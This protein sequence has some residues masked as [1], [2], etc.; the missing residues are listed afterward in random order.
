MQRDRI[1]RFMEAIGRDS[2][3]IVSS[4]SEVTRSNDT[5]YRFRPNSDFYYLTGFH[6]PDSIAVINPSHKDHKYVLF[7][8]PRDREREIWDGKRAGV[9]GAVRDYQADISFPIEEF[10]KRLPD[11][12]SNVKNLYYRIG[13]NDQ[14]MDRTVI[15]SISRLRSMGRRGISAPSAILDPGSILHEMRLKKSDKEISLMQQS[16]DIASEAHREAMRL[17]R[18]G[19]KEYEV[20]AIVEFVFRKHGAS[21]PAYNTIVGGGENATIL[22]YIDNNSTLSDGD[23]V[24]IDAGAEYMGYASDITRTFPVSG[25]FSEAQRAVYKLVLDTQTGCIDKVRPGVTMDELHNESVRLLTEGLVRL[26]LLSGNPEKLIE[27][28]TYKR[29]YMHRLG[30]FLGMDV[31]DVGQYYRDGESRPLEPGMVITVEPGIYISSETKEI[32]DQYRGI[33]IRIEDDVLV[34]AEGSKV[35]TSR[36]PKEIEEIE[37]LM[38]R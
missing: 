13:S 17:T 20:E 22:H 29:F 28:E 26:G 9:E 16:A 27:E 33:G 14:E 19:M 10:S 35:L 36:A 31:H 23:L 3:A 2:V 4:S 32:P 25:R 12:I 1:N 6:E 30:H 11:M 37:S 8:R 38:V 7:V 18:A 24:L 21:A 5:H 15:G 34:T